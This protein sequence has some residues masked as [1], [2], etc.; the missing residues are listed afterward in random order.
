MRCQRC[1][2]LAYRVGPFMICRNVWCAVLV[3]APR[4]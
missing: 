2:S 3:V 4:G 1:N